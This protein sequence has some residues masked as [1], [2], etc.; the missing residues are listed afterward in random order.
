MLKM[1]NLPC[2]DDKKKKTQKP[3]RPIQ[4]FALQFSIDS[5]SGASDI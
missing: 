1:Q 5:E 3:P 4:N 2:G